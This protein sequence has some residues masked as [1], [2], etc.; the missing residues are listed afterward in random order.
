LAQKRGNGRRV[1]KNCTMSSIVYS[2]PNFIRVINVGVRR[3]GHVARVGENRSVCM[4]FVGNPK[5]RIS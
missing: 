4:V 3:S 5:K 1:E 2:L